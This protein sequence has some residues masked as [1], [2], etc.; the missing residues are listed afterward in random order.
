MKRILILLLLSTP[1]HAVVAETAPPAS[2]G[3]VKAAAEARFQG[4]LFD[5]L[6]HLSALLP[7]RQ[8][9]SDDPN[10][11][12]SLGIRME[13]MPGEERR[14]ADDEKIVVVPTDELKYAAAQ[15]LLEDGRL[16]EAENAFTAFIQTHPSSALLPNARF[17]QALAIAAR[18]NIQRGKTLME[19]FAR[20]YPQHPL[21]GD[22]HRVAAA[23]Q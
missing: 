20:D 19:A 21:A 9:G 11:E 12:I 13:V 18:G 23:L 4:V 17:A 6:R 14:L 3:Q 22:A 2:P 10:Q 16:E 8:H 5:A 15:Q 7:K 1:G